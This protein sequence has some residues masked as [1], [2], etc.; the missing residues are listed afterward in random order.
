MISLLDKAA[1]KLG[2][3]AKVAEYLEIGQA[4]LSQWRSGHRPMPPYHAAQ[5]AELVGERW[6]D[7]TLECLAEHAKSEKEK[8]F[9]LGKAKELGKVAGLIWGIG[10]MLAHP[11]TNKAAS[12]YHS[13]SEYTLCAV[14]CV[15]IAPQSGSSCGRHAWPRTAAH[16]R[17]V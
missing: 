14:T 12:T 17:V 9:W 3:D 13:S 15:P 10:V 16:L 4:R 11:S 6:T 2:N 8:A 5:L 7:H 1:R